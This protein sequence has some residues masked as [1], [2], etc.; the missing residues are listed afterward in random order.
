MTNELHSTVEVGMFLSRLFAVSILTPH[1][2]CAWVVM[3]QDVLSPFPEIRPWLEKARVL[4]IEPDT[5]NTR[6]LCRIARRKIQEIWREEW[7]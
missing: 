5:Q 4:G 6:A 3:N 7:S 1:Q 2:K